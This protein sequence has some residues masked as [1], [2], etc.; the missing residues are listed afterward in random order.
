MKIDNVKQLP[1]LTLTLTLTERYLNNVVGH[2][3]LGHG[4][5]VLNVSTYYDK[6]RTREYR[7]I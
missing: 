2:P 5:H 4:V 7:G 1:H 3:M 6:Y